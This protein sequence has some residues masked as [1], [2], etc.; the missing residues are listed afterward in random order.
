VKKILF[1]F[2]ITMLT[3]FTGCKDTEPVKVPSAPEIKLDGNLQSL[4]M[5]IISVDSQKLVLGKNGLELILRSGSAGALFGGIPVIMTM[6]AS[7][8][9]N[10]WQLDKSMTDNFLR[11]LL[12]PVQRRY[13]VIL[14]DPGHGGHDAGAV[15]ASGVKEKDL[16]LQLSLLLAEALRAK[17][18]TVY[19]TRSDDRYLSLDARP[20]MIARYK[21]DL[22]I[23]VHHNSAAN[24]AASGH[25]V[26]FLRSENDAETALAIDSVQMAFQIEKSLFA[27]LPQTAVRGVKCARFKVLRLSSVP[28]ILIEAGFVSNP[29]EV[30]I[31]SSRNYQQLFA[32]AVASSF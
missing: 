19:L 24:T 8:Q 21:A 12:M 30:Q 25:E 29:D 28:S 2:T 3:A 1:L 27:H 5:Q 15:S 11:P 4:D 32:E 14:I 22:F 20:G 17:G 13:R 10:L 18:Y 6:P 16:N 26:Y 23:S 9:D 31:L 7:C